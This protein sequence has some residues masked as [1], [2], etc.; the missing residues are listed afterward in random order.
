MDDKERQEYEEEDRVFKEMI[1]SAEEFA[2]F[3]KFASD[4]IATNKQVLAAT[5]DKPFIGV[6]Y[7]AAQIDPLV[8]AMLWSKFSREMLRGLLA[9]AIAAYEYLKQ[10]KVT[11]AVPTEPKPDVAFL[12][13]ILDGIDLDV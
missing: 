10:G 1:G 4:F 11:A 6:L 7:N 2:D 8:E 12:D 3:S 13:S 5:Q 9:T